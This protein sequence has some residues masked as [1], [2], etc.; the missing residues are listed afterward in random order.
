MSDREYY[1]AYDERYRQVHSRNLQWASTTPTP[2]VAETIAE[3]SL[4]PNCR[5]LEIGCGEGRDAIHLLNLGYNLLATD[6]SQEA[7]RFCSTAAPEFSESFKTLDC[8]TENLDESFDFI[9]AVSVVHMLV[10]DDHLIQ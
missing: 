10:S 9:Y 3:F 7:I 1:A 8:I 4:A 5:L 6:I 2:I